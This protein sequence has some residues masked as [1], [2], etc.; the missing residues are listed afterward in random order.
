MSIPKQHIK[1]YILGIFIQVCYLILGVPQISFYQKP[2]LLML[3]SYFEGH[4]KTYLT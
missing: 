1:E 3:L 2:C 4:S